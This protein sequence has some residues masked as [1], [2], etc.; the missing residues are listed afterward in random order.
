MRLLILL[1]FTVY[2]FA[3]NLLTYNI[4][5]RTDR[6]DVMLSFDSPYEGKIY[7]KKMDNQIALT[8]EDLSFD[9]KIDKRIN[10]KIVQT[11]KII[12]HKNSLQILLGTKNKIGVIA[13]KTT[14]GFGLRIRAKLINVQNNRRVETTPL[15]AN[16]QNNDLQIIDQRY[17][18]VVVVLLILLVFMFWVKRRV[19]NSIPKN[20][21]KKGSWLFKNNPEENI[22]IK[23]IHKKPIDNQNSLL[24]VEFDNRRYLLMS[25]NSNVLIDTFSKSD[26]E[27]DSEFEK[28]FE[29]NRKKLDDFLKLQERQIDS[30]KNRVQA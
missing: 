10:S 29:E 25:G 19:T 2:G 20:S 3:S 16:N 17:T 23:I 4:Y 27:S 12:P 5:E 9:K 7:Q 8:L 1:F 21:N 30:Y 24:L 28:V 11:L 18:Y 15:L 14:D 13:S 26:V 6:V 22:E